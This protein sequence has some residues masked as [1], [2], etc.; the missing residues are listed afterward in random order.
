MRKIE[1][2]VVRIASR[3]PSPRDALRIYLAPCALASH[4]KHG[5]ILCVVLECLRPINIVQT[6]RP[7]GSIA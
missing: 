6:D 1:I 3:L 2:L 4:R 5:A 7:E